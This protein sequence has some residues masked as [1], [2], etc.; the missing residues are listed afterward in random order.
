MDGKANEISPSMAQ[1]LRLV[2]NYDEESGNLIWKKH[3]SPKHQRF[4]GRVAGS[5]CKQGYI[6][7]SIYNHPF[8]AHRLI[9]AMIHSGISSDEYIDHI[10][11]IKSDNRISNLR[12][13]TEAENHQNQKLCKRNKSGVKGVI[14]ESSRGLWRCQI[15]KNRKSYL[16]G[17]FKDIESAKKAIDKARSILHRDFAN[18][19]EFK[20]VD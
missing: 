20:N 10:N 1:Y 11:G 6:N 16:I 5:I 9:W 13:A 7:V 12:I 3:P 4:N 8:R 17:R 18:Y 15:T 14:W 19:G 2:L